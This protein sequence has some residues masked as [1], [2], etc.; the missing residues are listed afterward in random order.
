MSAKYKKNDTTT[1]ASTITTT[2]AVHIINFFIL[3]FLFLES[4]AEINTPF[5]S[6]DEVQTDK[7]STTEFAT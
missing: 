7:S 4:I 6:V 1:I 2:I 5:D 3:L